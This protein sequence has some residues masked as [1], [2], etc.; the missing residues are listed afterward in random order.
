MRGRVFLTSGLASSYT[1][2]DT[3]VHAV[4]TE[5]SSNFPSHEIV[6]EA[7]AHDTPSYRLISTPRF[8]WMAFFFFRETTHTHREERDCLCV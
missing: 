7:R 2:D 8:F 3:R 1:R 4:R 5:D 6:G